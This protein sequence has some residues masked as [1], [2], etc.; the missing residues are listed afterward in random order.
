M[1]TVALLTIIFVILSLVCDGKLLDDSTEI[2]LC[3]CFIS[4]IHLIYL[5]AMKEKILKRLKEIE[6]DR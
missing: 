6:N 4:D 1:I 5:S 2:L 3:I